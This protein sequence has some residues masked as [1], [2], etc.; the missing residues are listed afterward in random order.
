MPR[1][2]PLRVLPA[3]ELDDL[4]PAQHWTPL[5]APTVDGDGDGDGGAGNAAAEL[6]RQMEVLRPTLLQRARAWDLDF[7]EGGGEN[8]DGDD[9]AAA[10]DDGVSDRAVA[11]KRLPL[12]EFS[13]VD[14]GAHQ[15]LADESPDWRCCNA[16]CRGRVFD[17]LRHPMFVSRIHTRGIGAS[18]SSRRA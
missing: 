3:M 14:C 8:G 6:R 11:P 13:C 10:G 7:A 16:P 12:P 17:A 2:L 5:L 15:F 18:N 4:H 9:G 1:S